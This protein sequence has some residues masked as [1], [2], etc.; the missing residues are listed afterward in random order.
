ML[1]KR[2]ACLLTAS[3]ALSLCSTTY[4]DI[5]SAWWHDDGDGAIVCTDWTFSGQALTMKGN[6][7]SSPGHMLAWVD[8]TDT[9]DPSLT[10]GNSI[11]NDTTI[12][13]IGYQVNVIMNVPFTF[14]PPGPSADNP[15]TSGGW[16]LANIWAPTLQTGGDYPGLYEG[17]LFF[18]GT[19]I[20]IGDELDYL[21]TVKFSGSTHY[22]L[23]QEAFAYMTLV[24][25]PGTLALLGMGGLMLALRVRRN[26]RS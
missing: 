5:T 17:S 26:R 25:E 23:T 24:P 18:N 2:L 21:Y 15:P 22:T 3:A 7:Y 14:V 4:A 8:T 6:Q 9:V 1:M 13:W 10:L 11:N 20:N 19:A 16:Y 12:P